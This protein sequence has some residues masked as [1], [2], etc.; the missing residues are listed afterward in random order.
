M[1]TEL[2]SFGHLL[3]IVSIF[4]AA[5]LIKTAIGYRR[6]RLWGNRNDLSIEAARIRWICFPNVHIFDVTIVENS[7]RRRARVTLYESVWRVGEDVTWLDQESDDLN[8][9]EGT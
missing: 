4:A 2:F 7:H 6:L 3:F 8:S 9:R 5:L 1:Q